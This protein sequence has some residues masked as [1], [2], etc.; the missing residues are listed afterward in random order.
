MLVATV[1]WV[2]I[3]ASLLLFAFYLY[4]TGRLATRYTV[5]RGNDKKYLFL[6]M[7]TQKRNKKTYSDTTYVMMMIAKHSIPVA[8][9]V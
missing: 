3:H 2:A 1:P 9:I 4:A 5:S 7:C 6:Q 8:L